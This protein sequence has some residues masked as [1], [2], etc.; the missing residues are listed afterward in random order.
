MLNQPL[1]MHVSQSIDVGSVLGGRY[2]V[3]EFVLTSAEGDLVLEGI[4]QVLNRSVSIL[5]ASTDNSSQLASSAREIA[6]D[7]RSAE[8]QV[9]DLGVTD[10]NQ[11][12]LVA[13]LANSAD[14]LD[15]V[16]ERDAPYV[17]PFF[18]DTLGTEIFGESRQAVPQ[19]YEDDDAYYEHLRYE[20]EPEEQ[21]RIGNA[22][23]SGF[24]GL[25]N[26][27]GRKNASAEGD[28]QSLPSAEGDDVDP[29]TAPQ[30]TSSPS[31]TPVAPIKGSE[32]GAKPADRAKVTRLEDDEPNVTATAALSSAELSK[33]KE[34]KSS[35]DKKKPAAAGA[36]SAAAAAS[37]S[38]KKEPRGDKPTG[39]QKASGAAGAAGAGGVA[40]AA[41]AASGNGS[42]AKTFPAAAKNVPAS[43]AD[44]ENPEENNENSSKGARL[45]VGAVLIAVLV[46]GV[47][48]AFNF[49]GRGG[50][51]EPVA[52]TPPNETQEQPAE[53][54]EESP[55][56]TESPLPA[57]EIADVSRLVP[58]NQKLNAETDD[59][60]SK[61]IDG[62]PASVY[63]TY[64]YTTA[65]FGGFASNMVF[66]LELED[67]SK[68]SEV[69][70][71]GLNASGGSYQILIGDSEDLGEANSVA[72]GSFTGP[73][74]T[75]P[76]NEEQATG[77]YVFLNV[78][79][80]PRRAS[81]AN[82][83]RPFGLQIGEFSAK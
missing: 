81:G 79:E 64:S 58:G 14:L 37:E 39:S 63:N 50:G 28:E 56:D 15:L 26:R 17:E 80:L 57:P 68:I 74:L 5:V 12:Y 6:M 76:V 46:I 41:A 40:A 9:L 27:F 30:E 36:T 29:K 83:S 16:V 51:D 18:T 13:N 20:E 75:V 33:G 77:Q 47:V 34:P 60:L 78:T 65:N 32:G 35:K 49:L 19:T 61:M 53:P 82:A 72:N 45:L 48:F 25:K 3:T 71:D 10:A 54:N 38:P 23:S 70:L 55:S 11:T 42:K 43:N 22:L 1:E 31:T 66:I 52:Q 62:N 7:E 59:T 67:E 4:D 44:Y 73:S 2:Q 69:Q 21:G 24:S 8:V